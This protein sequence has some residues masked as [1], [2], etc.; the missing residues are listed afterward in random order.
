MRVKICGI[1]NLDDALAAVD[2]GADALGFVFAEEAKARNRFI[3]PEDA[4]E[5]I[6]KL[7][8]FITT[9]A[10]TVNDP[11]ELLAQYLIYMD[12][13]QLHGEELPGHLPIEHLAIKAFRARPDMMVDEML[14]YHT[15]A[16]LI[17]A[18]SG[19]TRGG[20]GHT[21]DWEL[22]KAAVE[23]GRPVI[24][25]GGLT[26]DNVAEA[27]QTVRPFAVDTSSGVEAAP[28]KKDHDKVRRFIHNAKAS[29]A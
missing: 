3:A 14:P 11:M 19:D 2:A 26:P 6:S 9:V 10:V 24:L 1:T 7:P 29:L 5:I 18:Y 22:A 12:C 28:G 23:T 4:Y 16:W 27:I 8:P 25:A 15:R 13:I 17:D 20:T 21:C